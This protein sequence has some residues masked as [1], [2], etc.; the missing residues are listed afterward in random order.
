M[1]DLEYFVEELRDEGH[2][3]VIFMDANQ[4]S[5]DVINNKI[6][7][8]NSNQIRVFNIEGTIDSLLK[9]FVQ[10]KGLHN[11]LNTKHGEEN[12]SSIQSLGSSAIDYVYVLEGLLEHVVGIGM[13]NF[14]A[15][16]LAIIGLSFLIL[17]LNLSLGQN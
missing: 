10:N 3:V 11:I 9:N 1:L 12:R 15:N 13:L 4:T 8:L 6:T 7:F 16:L 2:E 17:T 5:L 14:D